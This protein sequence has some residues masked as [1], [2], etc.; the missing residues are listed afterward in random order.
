MRTVGHTVKDYRL[1][2]SSTRLIQADSDSPAFAAAREY[3]CLRS[4]DSRNPS[5]ADSPL[6]SLGLPRDRFMDGLCFNK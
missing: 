4:G 3:L 6:S 1:A 2:R 5:Q